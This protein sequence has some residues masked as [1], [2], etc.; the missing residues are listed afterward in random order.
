MFYRH[1]KHRPVPVARSAMKLRSSAPGQNLIHITLDFI[2][3]LYGDGV[4]VKDN[5]LSCLLVVVVWQVSTPMADGS[6]LGGLYKKGTP[7]ACSVP[8]QSPCT[9]SATNAIQSFRSSVLTHY[10]H[11]FSFSSRWGSG[12]KST[13][14]VLTRVVFTG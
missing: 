2:C 13:S 7:S 5:V 8:T 12:R 14:K 3:P 11:R 9:P 4:E 1:F 6:S 10:H